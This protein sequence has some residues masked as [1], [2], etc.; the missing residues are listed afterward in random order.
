M[1]FMSMFGLG[2]AVGR[3]AARVW[4]AVRRRDEAWKD[5]VAGAARS[6]RGAEAHWAKLGPELAFAL[7]LRMFMRQRRHVK[8]RRAVLI[9]A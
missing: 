4:S 7:M 8:G 6:S 3:P 5:L 9:V 1:C 2:A